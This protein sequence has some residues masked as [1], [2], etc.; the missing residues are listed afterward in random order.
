MNH[1]T[2]YFE[3]TDTFCGETNYAWLRRFT[4]EAKNIRGALIKLSRET[5]LNFRYD[6]HFYKAKNACVVAYT[7][8]FYSE[9]IEKDWIDRSVKLGGE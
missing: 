8:D 1:Q 9:E 4:I 2:F 6:G 3:M 7:T 5:G